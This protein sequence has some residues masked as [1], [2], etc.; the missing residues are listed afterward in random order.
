LGNDMDEL[1]TGGSWD[2]GAVSSSLDFNIRTSL[3]KYSDDSSRKTQL[4]LIPG[5]V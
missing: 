5:I 1:L 2:C 4:L 3:A